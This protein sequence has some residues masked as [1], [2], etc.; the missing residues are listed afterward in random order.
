LRIVTLNAN[1]IRA[2]SK[3][4]FF[5]WAAA[6]GADLICLQETRAQEHQ[7]PAEALVLPG[8][9]AY[10]V[11]SHKR[12]YSGVA[13]YS[14]REPADVTRSLGWPD[15]DDEGRFVQLDFGAF[16]VGS[17]YVPSGVSG[18]PRQ[19]FKMSFLERFLGFMAK[20]K[21]SGRDHIICGDYNIAHKEIDTFDPVRNSRITGFL[22]DERA[23]LDTLIDQVGWVDAFRVVN[24]ERK[25]YTWWA[26]WPQAWPNN[27]GWRIDYEMITPGLA[28]RVQ[29]A[30]IYKDA[31]FSDH[32]PL[33]VDYDVPF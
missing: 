8:F 29:D 30:S 5:P 3:R 13:I 20:L 1:G 4:G 10:Y 6:Q 31:R 28:R 2:A 27:L 18:P 26:N 24:K 17:V 21:H 25:Q 16:T 9:T 32:A 22:P 14:R 12:G 11:D 7:L 15:V 19:A 23:W 33:T